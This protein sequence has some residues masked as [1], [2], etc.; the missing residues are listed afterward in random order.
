MHF[1]S[2]CKVNNHT[3]KLDHDT[4]VFQTCTARNVN[5]HMSS[6]VFLALRRN[7]FDIIDFL[8]HK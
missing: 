3:N 7:E 2:I 4:R 8:L 1:S 6:N 5:I